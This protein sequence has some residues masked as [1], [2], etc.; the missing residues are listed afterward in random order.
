MRDVSRVTEENRQMLKRIVSVQ[1]RYSREKWE[2]EW[3]TNL[4][5]IDQ[6]S[7]YP[8]DWWKYQD[9]VITVKLRICVLFS[10]TFYFS[11]LNSGF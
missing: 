10:R 8:P 3:Q 7:A 2:Q 5:L 1:P 9:Q 4:Q 11:R 6:M